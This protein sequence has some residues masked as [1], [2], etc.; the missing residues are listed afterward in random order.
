MTNADPIAAFTLP[1]L[2]ANSSARARNESA[3]AKSLTAIA[4]RPASMSAL[5]FFGFWESSLRLAASLSAGSLEYIGTST[6]AVPGG[7]DCADAIPHGKS[8]ESVSQYA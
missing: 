1:L 8:N 5:T 4:L 2:G 3:A 7:N 6:V